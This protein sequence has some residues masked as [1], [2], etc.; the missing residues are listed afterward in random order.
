MNDI[1]LR[2]R[3]LLA[4]EWESRGAWVEAS[5]VRGPMYAGDP[6]LC[7]ITAALTLREGELLAG[8][9]VNLL[10]QQHPSVVAAQVL[11]V[12]PAAALG[13]DETGAIGI[14]GQGDQSL[15]IELAEV[16]PEH[17][18]GVPAVR[19]RP[20]TGNL[21]SGLRNMLADIENLGAGPLTVDTALLRQAIAALTPQWQPIE[22]APKD[23]SPVLLTS[24]HMTGPNDTAVMWAAIY[25]AEDQRF[26]CTWDGEPLWD[27]THWMP[28]PAAPEVSP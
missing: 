19:Y 24:A 23:G 13:A 5:F 18:V 28:L 2:A 16:A 1:E 9:A 7:A 15:G 8:G 12:V 21:V 17:E 10:G 22:A 6:V 4:A 11:D 3:E 14:G 20:I 26:I 27:A 25:A